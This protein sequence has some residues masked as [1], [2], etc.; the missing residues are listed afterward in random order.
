MKLHEIVLT[1]FSGHHASKAAGPLTWRQRMWRHW[2]GWSGRTGCTPS[3]PPSSP[4]PLAS[5]TFKPAQTE[6]QAFTLQPTVYRKNFKDIKSWQKKKGNMYSFLRECHQ[7]NR[8]ML[9]MSYKRKGSWEKLTQWPKR[10]PWKPDLPLPLKLSNY[11]PDL[12][13]FY[14]DFVFLFNHLLCI[15]L[16]DDGKSIQRVSRRVDRMSYIRI[17]FG[18]LFD[19]MVQG[20]Y[21]G[22]PSPPKNIIIC[23]S[24]QTGFPPPPLRLTWL[25]PGTSFCFRR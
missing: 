2:T 10:R 4:Q 13:T 21:L 16:W 22:I 14:K 20:P 1:P 3:P 19:T 6:P 8:G 11:S 17:R 7:V 24:I 25:V 12:M 18:S 5:G 23:Y 9:L 15:I